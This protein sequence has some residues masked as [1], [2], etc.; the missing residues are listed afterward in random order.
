MQA[1][2]EYGQRR[3]EMVLAEWAGVRCRVSRIGEEVEKRRVCMC[4][5]CY[6]GCCGVLELL[7]LLYEMWRFFMDFS[8]GVFGMEYV[9]VYV[10]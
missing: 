4:G 9:Y 7:V 6:R 1:A 10:V 8:N 2:S 5:G 3:R